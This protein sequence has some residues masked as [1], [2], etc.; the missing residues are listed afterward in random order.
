VHQPLDYL[1][2]P[3][4]ESF[5]NKHKWVMKGYKEALDASSIISITD[6][7][8]IIEYANDK[9][10]EISKY[11]QEE[12][13]GKAHSIVRHPDMSKQVFKDMWQTIKS[14]KIWQGI[15]KNLAKDGSVYIVDT[16]IVPVTDEA[17]NIHHFVSIRHD[18]TAITQKDILIEKQTT[19]NLT[20]LPNR[21]LLLEDL[22]FSESPLVS[23]I[24]IDG[25]SEINDFYGLDIG[26]KLLISVAEKLSDMLR[27]IKHKLYRLHGD[28]FAVLTTD[29]DFIADHLRLVEE[30]L[31]LIKNEPFDC[32]GQK[33]YIS[34]T[35]GSAFESDT[36]LGKANMALKHA[37]SERKLH[38]I[39]DSSVKLEMKFGENI[40]WSNKIHDAIGDCRIVSY[41]QPIFNL[42]TGVIEK[43]EALVRLID[44]E[45]VI[46]SP[47][48]FLEIAKK[49]KQYS[50]ITKIMLKNAVQTALETGYEISVNLSVEDLENDEI[51]VEI[52]HLLD[53][54]GVGKKMVFELTETEEVKNYDAVASFIEL[55]KG[56]YGSK[57]AI[58][59]FGSG[60]SNFEHLLELDFDYL[61]IDGSIIEKVDKTKESSIL[62]EAIIAFTQKL[63]IK[64]IAEFVSSQDI[65]DI[66][67]E[68]GI[69]YAQGYYIGKPKSVPSKD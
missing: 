15:V 57:V 25:F 68:K 20:G 40:E 60:Y 34:A 39:Y 53:S 37:R 5:E 30:S 56:V 69:H 65:Y 58:D 47:W 23:I 36:I 1:E 16:T 44:A 24:N 59:D 42:G 17:G 11:S 6:A 8:G 12:L 10:C 7:N 13:I 52:K 33:I 55:V 54:Y 21:V 31:K 46:I 64:T 49:S 63:D 9:F 50:Q 66:V 38:Q 67:K 45:G 3:H 35:S 41:Y 51:I 14:G 2:L 28:E 29:A 18:L 22:E 61:K 43:Y 27:T 26:D 32:D 62:V 19:D 48:Q 4:K